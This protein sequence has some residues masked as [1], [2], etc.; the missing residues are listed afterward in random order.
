MVAKQEKIVDNNVEKKK[1]V[2]L[3]KNILNKMRPLLGTKT[4]RRVGRG[5]GSGIG[6]TSGRGDKGQY[7]RNQ[8]PAL[9]LIIKNLI[10]KLPKRGMAGK[11]VTQWELN[12]DQLRNLSEK[13]SIKKWD[14][15]SLLQALKA[16]KKYKT[17]KI[18]HNLATENMPA[19]ELNVDRISEGAKT[20]IE[21]NKG[22][23]SLIAPK[24]VWV[25]TRKVDG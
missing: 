3:C 14:T 1:I 23:V 25:R 2:Y 19:L 18:I 24:Q 11:V 17:V 22:S 12:I 15:T 4:K 16:P 6:K 13:N 7:A 21:K 9:R 5:K 20:F 8:A 10:R